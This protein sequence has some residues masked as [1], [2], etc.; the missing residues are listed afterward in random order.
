[1]PLHSNMLLCRY[2][3][4][5]EHG[6]YLGEK[7]FKE[8]YG[9]YQISRTGPAPV[10]QIGVNWILTILDS[11]NKAVKCYF[12]ISFCLGIGVQYI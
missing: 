3:S 6:I 8:F 12:Y 1:M 11:C 2:T 9:F 10:R 5:L 4:V 7:A